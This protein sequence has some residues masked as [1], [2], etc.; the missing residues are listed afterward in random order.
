[1]QEQ[2]QETP[3]QRLTMLADH[4]DQEL[5]RGGAGGT[6]AGSTDTSA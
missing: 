2:G 5:L 6:P 3:Q 1:M 4:N